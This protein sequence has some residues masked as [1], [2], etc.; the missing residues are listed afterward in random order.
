MISH[1]HRCIFV[2]IPKTGGTSVE[3]LIWPSHAKRSDADLWMGFI[4]L[5]RNKYQTG[6]L[7]HL[8]ASQIR[9][10][11]GDTVFDN[12]FKFSIVR[13]PW[14][15]AV[16]Q[17]V[18]MSKRTDLREYIGMG[19][20]DGFKRYLNLISS[21]KHVQWEPQVSFL[22]DANR[23]CIVDY[24][25]RF[26]NFNHSV[27]LI[28]RKI[29]IPISKIPHTNKGK[30]RDVEEYYDSESREIVAAMYEED[31]KA[32]GYS[33]AQCIQ[34]GSSPEEAMVERGHPTRL[35]AL[36]RILGIGSPL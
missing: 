5:Y 1:K 22:L 33:F 35:D 8:C 29:G 4:D 7:Q 32:F 14:D 10:E 23:N 31:I 26:E 30:R 27:E 19:P 15:K 6:G 2:H 13:N 20:K 17:Y 11:I 34:P 36:R 18:Y 21:R 9:E 12:Y 28:A 16:S 3:D 24:I 25:G